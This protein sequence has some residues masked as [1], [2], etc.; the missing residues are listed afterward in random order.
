MERMRVCVCVCVCVCVDESSAKVG[1]WVSKICLHVPKREESNAAFHLE[2]TVA[3]SMFCSSR[4]EIFML[5][6]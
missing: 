4:D 2:S 3:H 5:P 6:M 1:N